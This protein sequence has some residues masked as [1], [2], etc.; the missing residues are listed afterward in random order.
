MVAEH[1]SLV[2]Q[3]SGHRRKEKPRRNCIHPM[4]FEKTSI[5]DRIR[6]IQNRIDASFEGRRISSPHLELDLRR[7]GERQGIGTE[8]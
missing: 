1:L 7:G 8:L 3:L 5:A 2:I 4:T 6:R